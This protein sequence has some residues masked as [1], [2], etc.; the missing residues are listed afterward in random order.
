MTT[1]RI[2][3]LFFEGCPHAEAALRLARSVAGW[4]APD[5]QVSQ[6]DIDSDEVAAQ[7]HF[8]G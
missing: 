6:V 2:E 4:L 1:P 7:T 5:A 3:V 8:Y